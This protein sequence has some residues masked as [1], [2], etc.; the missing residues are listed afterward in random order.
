[1]KVSPFFPYRK[2]LRIPYMTK[3]YAHAHKGK[4]SLR[5]GARRGNKRCVGK[6]NCSRECVKRTFVLIF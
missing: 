2:F 4:L 6:S 3:K 5:D 1:M